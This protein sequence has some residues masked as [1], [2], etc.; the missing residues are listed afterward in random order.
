MRPRFDGERPAPFA[1]ACRLATSH[2]PAVSKLLSSDRSMTSLAGYFFWI[3]SSFAIDPGNRRMPP[4]ARQHQPLLARRTARAKPGG[5]W[6]AAP[7]FAS[8]SI[9]PCI[10]CCSVNMFHT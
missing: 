9:G 2:A 4:V 10:F 6:H 7:A 8:G 3:S 5:G 1:K